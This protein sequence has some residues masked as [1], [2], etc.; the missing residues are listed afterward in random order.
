MSDLLSDRVDEVR[1]THGS[2]R[3][4]FFNG[5]A[6]GKLTPIMA[7][8]DAWLAERV[9]K[10]RQKLDYKRAVT[11]FADWLVSVK[12]PSDIEGTARKTAGRYVTEAF[13]GRGVHWKT[14]NKSISALSGY[15]KWMNKKG[16]AS[17]NIWALQSLPKVK[18][19]GVGRHT[20]RPFTDDEVSVLLRGNPTLVLLDA[21]KIAALSG[22]R[23]E[24]IARLKV[25]HCANGIMEITDAKTTAGMRSVPIHSDIAAII[26]RR[27]EGKVSG[28]YLF[29]ELTTPPKG[30]AMERGQPITK[31]FVSYRKLYCAWKFV[32][33]GAQTG[34]SK[35]D[36]AQLSK[37]SERAVGYMR[38]AYSDLSKIITVDEFSG[39]TQPDFDE[40]RLLNMSWRQAKGQAY[41]ETPKDAD[42][43]EKM[44]RDWARRIAKTFG[45]KFAQ[46]PDVAGAALEYYSRPLVKNLC[47]RWQ[48]ELL[49]ATEVDGG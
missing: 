31:G 20:K 42:W 46:Q 23:T 29:D 19:A 35:S 9:M 18:L 2:N 21:S 22:M 41:G 1:A 5:V 40:T 10:P 32:A 24:E 30:S 6:L 8:V 45:K 37:V 15:W 14:A 44:G 4:L 43:E 39:A 48:D 33:M 13:V 36:I 12:L 47:E 17:E 11:R 34:L 38:V 16:Y 26:K 3:A 27:C 28:A 25:E 49:E 7:P